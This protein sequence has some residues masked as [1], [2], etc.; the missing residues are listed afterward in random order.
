MIAPTGETE[1]QD[2]VIA[3]RPATTPDAAPSE[4]G[5]P[6]RM[7]SV[8]SQPRQAAPVATMVLTHATAAV[9]PAET[10]D[11]ALKPNQPNHSSPAPSM[12]RVRLCGRIGSLRQPIRFPMIRA[13]ARP[14]T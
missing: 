5:W 13:N 10:A 12:T 14:A 9:L 11:P 3:T 6:S 8:I 2:G 1:E 4:V 7:R